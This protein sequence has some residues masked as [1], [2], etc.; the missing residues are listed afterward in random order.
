M[1]NEYP[2]RDKLAPCPFCRRR[3]G[4]YYSYIRCYS[5]KWEIKIYCNHCGALGPMS[6]RNT[7]EKHKVY[8][9]EEDA[10]RAAIAA[11]NNLLKP[12]LSRRYTRCWDNDKRLKRRERSKK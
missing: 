2:V 1:V 8:T 11:W 4:L 12:E 9:R 3:D 5:A 7:W 10:K 6:L